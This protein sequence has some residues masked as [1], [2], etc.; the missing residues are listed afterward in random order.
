MQATRKEKTPRILYDCTVLTHILEVR[1]EKRGFSAQSASCRQMKNVPMAVLVLFAHIAVRWI[2]ILCLKINAV[3][4]MLLLHC[5]C[6]ASN[7]H[8]QFK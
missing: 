5:A 1:P 4:F 8:F 7:F 6:F 2:G 3:G